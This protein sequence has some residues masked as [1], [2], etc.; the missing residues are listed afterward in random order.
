MSRFQYRMSCVRVSIR[1]HRCAEATEM[2]HQQDDSHPCATNAVPWRRGQITCATMSAA[3][4]LRPQAKHV[5]ERCFATHPSV[6][7]YAS[8]AAVDVKS[9]VLPRSARR[10]SVGTPRRSGANRPASARGEANR[11]IP[12][13]C[14]RKVRSGRC[15]RQARGGVKFVPLGG[16]MPSGADYREVWQ[17]R[18]GI[19]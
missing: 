1:A 8:T 19:G 6:V 5:N 16:I 15:S 12:L 14:R 9:G 13:L 11:T 18:L 4:L 17:D 2:N 7:N 10:R 3:S